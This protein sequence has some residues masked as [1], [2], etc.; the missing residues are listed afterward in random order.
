[1]LNHKKENKAPATT[2]QKAAKSNFPKEKAIILNAPKID[3]KVP[4][5]KPSNPSIMP[6]DQQAMVIKMNKGDRQ[7]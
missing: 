3:A 2:A 4:P 7:E 5:A 6:P 1:M